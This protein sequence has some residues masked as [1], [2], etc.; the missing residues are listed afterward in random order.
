MRIIC[1]LFVVVA[2]QA[3]DPQCGVKSVN[4]PLNDR[5]IGGRDALPMEWPWQVSMQAVGND[6]HICGGTIINSQWIMTAAHC[7]TTYSTDP[8]KWKMVLGAQHMRQKDSTKR[9]FF[10]SKVRQSQVLE[11]GEN[12]LRLINSDYS[13]RKMARSKLDLSEMTLLSTSLR[14]LLTSPLINI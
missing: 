3:A 13:P 11:K 5:I 4:P 6:Y 8:S 9:E 2:A 14:N 10:L 1:L 7:A 12:E